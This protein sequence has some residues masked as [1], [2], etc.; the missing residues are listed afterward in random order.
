MLVSATIEPA[1][2]LAVDMALGAA[3][4]DVLGMVF[5]MGLRLI[6]IGII[7][8]VL[9][10]FAATRVISSQPSDQDHLSRR[11]DD[12]DRLQQHWQAERHDRPAWPPDE[13]SVRPDGPTDPDHLSGRDDRIL[14][15]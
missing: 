9:V 12:P 1:A 8:G 15:L 3:A 7:T 13:L 4:S 5:R 14:H 6:A 10:T 11:I 2:A